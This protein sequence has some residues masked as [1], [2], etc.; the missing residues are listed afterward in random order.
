MNKRVLLLLFH[1]RF[2]TSVVNKYLLNAVSDMP[3]VRIHD[4]YEHYPD[5]N[6]A[7]K[8]EQALLLEHE[9]V[10]FQHPFYWY[11]FPPLMKQWIDLVL[12]H[13]WAY[14]RSGNQL[15]HKW[16]FNAVTTGGAR[17]AYSHE[18]RNSHTVGEFL[19]AMKQTCRLCGMTYLPPFVVHNANRASNAELEAAANQYRKVLQRVSDAQFDPLMAASSPY[20][21]DLIN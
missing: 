2:E 8:R 10:I 1:P 16:V 12:E 20:L 11:N 5:F 4:V 14:G 7:V 13:G 18:G 21:N 15:N 6:V 19:F 3:N 17:E 9:L